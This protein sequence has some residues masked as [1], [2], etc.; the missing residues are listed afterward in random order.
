MLRRAGEAVQIERR[1][2]ERMRAQGRTRFVLLSGV[3]G[4]GLP[5][6]LVV[7]VAIQILTGE[8]LP[9]SLLGAGF[10]AR[11]L[12]AV[13]VFSV[14]GCLSAYTTWRLHQRR[15]GQGGAGSAD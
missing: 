2:W 3:L 7:A 15:F 6:G 4:R 5:L 9:E 14:S 10:L 13:A 11:A 8:P 1:E 12:L